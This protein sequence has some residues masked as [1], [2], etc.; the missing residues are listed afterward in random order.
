MDSFSLC[1][2]CN[3][4]VKRGS[5]RCPFC[6]ASLVERRSSGPEWSWMGATRATLFAAAFAGCERPTPAV[7][8]ATTHP[9][10]A[11]QTPDVPTSDS[12]VATAVF[13]AS[14]GPLTAMLGL[15]YGAPPMGAIQEGAVHG[16]AELTAVDSE[17][18][19]GATSERSVTTVLRAQIGALRDCYERVLRNNPTAAGALSIRFTVDANGRVSE[20]STTGLDNEPA[21]GSCVGAR[22]RRLAFARPAGAPE[23]LTANVRFE[24]Q[25]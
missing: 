4:H 19:T 3:R 16:R 5:E 25:R 22:I 18:A 24:R 21:L 14:F 7:E 1:D 6:D 11:Q 17:L 12:G 20:L 8:Q 9:P 10:V 13:D 15:G 2:A 23:T